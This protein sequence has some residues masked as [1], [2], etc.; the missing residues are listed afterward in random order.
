MELACVFC[1]PGRRVAFV[2]E[3]TTRTLTVCRVLGLGQ[4]WVPILRRLDDDLSE[5]LA[6]RR[7]FLTDTEPVR[8]GDLRIVALRIQG[9]GP[10]RIA[11]RVGRRSVA[12]RRHIE[13]TCLAVAIRLA[14]RDAPG[15]SDTG[16]HRGTAGHR[17]V[18][19]G[20]PRYSEDPVSQEAFDRLWLQG[21][22][23]ND[24][25]AALSLGPSAAKTH[26]SAAPPRWVG[27][28]VAAWLGW[29]RENHR[30]RLARGYFPA[31]DGRDSR[32]WWWP[33]TVTEWAATQP[34]VQCP[35]CNS[36]VLRLKQHLVKHEKGT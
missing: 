2:A 11:D 34:F 8:L 27:K 35:Q 12:S 33:A 32:D 24:I 5:P 28:K 4:A 29:S 20:L 14:D 31:P 6:W 22:P 23:L 25:R 13:R 16:D 7:R 30:L 19:D 3:P 21:L 9:L 10:T 18:Q 26:V 1:G 17:L 36:S 15:G